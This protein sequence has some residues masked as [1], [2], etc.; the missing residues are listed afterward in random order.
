M[1]ALACLFGFSLVVL[2]PVIANDRLV[3]TAKNLDQS[4]SPASSNRHLVPNRWWESLA[5]MKIVTL[6]KG[7][8]YAHEIDIDA[9]RASAQ[10]D[11][12]KA[13]GFRAIE[14]FA[15]AHGLYGYNG[16]DTVNH[17]AIDPELGTMADFKRF[18]QI[19][20]NKGLAVVAF[21]NIGYFSLEAPD[22]LEA[23]DNPDGE[24]AK[25]FIWAD[26]PDAPIPPENIYF[27]WP[28]GPESPEKTWGWQ[29]SER[30]GRYFWA[31]WQTRDEDGNWVGL[32]Q[33]DWGYEGWAK[34]A[35]N[36]VRHWMDT[37]LDGLIIDAPIYYIGLTWDKNNRYITDVIESY[38]NTFRQPEGSERVGWVAEGNYNCI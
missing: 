3:L 12:I 29:Y 10:L 21:I 11:Q 5:G 38:G 36:I 4:R 19:A 8:R 7:R 2:N 16:L 32:P 15:P 22:W 14:I 20:H 30:A 1:I 37:G 27:N 18:V 13:E 28:R 26:S 6:K 23:C 34:E 25:W 24:R 33:N 17:Y 31:K 9:E 35:G